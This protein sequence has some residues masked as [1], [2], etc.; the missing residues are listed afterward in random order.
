MFP[1]LNLSESESLS[2]KSL[3]KIVIRLPTE[4]ETPVNSF[5]SSSL[6]HNFN[7]CLTRNQRRSSYLQKNTF[8]LRK[9]TG[10]KETSRFPPSSNPHHMNFRPYF[11]K[12][13]F[14]SPTRLKKDSSCLKT[15]SYEFS[16]QMLSTVIT[17][18]PQPIKLK[19]SDKKEYRDLLKKNSLKVSLKNEVFS[20][21]HRSKPSLPL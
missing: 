6:S 15:T 18:T 10:L 7:R 1:K 2:P 5:D 12:F 11:R 3:V 20:R 16:P 4:S 17:S 14:D 13:S 21:I 19:L 8:I 9:S